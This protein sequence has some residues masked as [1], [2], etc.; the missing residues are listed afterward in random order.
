MMQ[1]PISGPPAD[2]AGLLDL[3]SVMGQC[4]TFGAIAGRC[5]AAH[6]ATLKRLREER[7]YL[8][9]SANW[10]AFCNEYLKMSQTQADHMIRLWDEFGAG[11]FELAQLTRISPETYRA[12]AP[13]IHDGALHCNGHA[14]EL[15]VENSRRVAAVVADLRRSLPAAK[16]PHEIPMPQRLSRLDKQCARIVAEFKAISKREQHGDYWLRFTELLMRWSTALRR[17]ESENG[18]D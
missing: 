8:R 12:L 3:G 15:S 9:V 16:P 14:I 11:Y 17:I 13:A 5:S 7:G 10:R 2:D 4:H 1:E 6:A 18:L